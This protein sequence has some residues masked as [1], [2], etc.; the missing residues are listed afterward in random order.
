MS[1][2]KN[3]FENWISTT[4]AAE[5]T[6]YQATWLQEMARRDKVTAQKLAG[7]WLFNKADLLQ[8]KQKMD[9]LGRK[10]HA[11]LPESQQ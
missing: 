10:K 7:R 6:G 11:G 5:L 1:D 4:H 2:E 9:A 8:Y 3:I